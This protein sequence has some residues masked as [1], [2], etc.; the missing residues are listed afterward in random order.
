M[1]AGYGRTW[2]IDP[3]LTGIEPAQIVTALILFVLNE[4]EQGAFDN[5]F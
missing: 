3:N 5:S 1:M 2:S 4:F